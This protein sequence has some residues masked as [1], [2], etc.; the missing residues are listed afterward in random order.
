MEGAK[1]WLSS[2]AANFLDTGTQKH[3]P[4]YYKHLNSNG[5][6]VEK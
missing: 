6:Y 3:I 1:T 4:Q 2:Q 5:G